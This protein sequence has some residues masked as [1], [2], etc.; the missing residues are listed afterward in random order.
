[1]PRFKG[2]KEPLIEILVIRSWWV[3]L[4]LLLF[5]LGFDQ[6]LKKKNQDIAR[7]HERIL[8]LQQERFIAIDEQEDLQLRLQSQ[9]DS[10]WVAMV[11]IRELGL[12][13]KGKVKVHFAKDS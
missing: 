12:V 11:L 9:N 3:F 6:A 1:M 5:Y 13:P 7:L 4:F 2:L 10:D 8:N